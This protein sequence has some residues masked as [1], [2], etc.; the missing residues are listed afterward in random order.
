MALARAHGAHADRAAALV[1]AGHARV[2]GFRVRAPGHF[3]RAGVVITLALDRTVR[4]IEVVA[5]C[6]K[7]GNAGAARLLYRDLA[8]RPQAGGPPED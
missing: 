6:E 8:A 5:F 1:E 3:V 2:K 4:V 7:R